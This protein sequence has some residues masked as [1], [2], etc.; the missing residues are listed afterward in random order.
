MYVMSIIESAGAGASTAALQD[1]LQRS[2]LGGEAAQ[3][4]GQRDRR[5]AALPRSKKTLRVK[6]TTSMLSGGGGGSGGGSGGGGGG[7]GS[8][9]LGVREVKARL[10]ALGARN[11]IWL[12][13]VGTMCL[14]SLSWLAS[15]VGNMLTCVTSQFWCKAWT[16]VAVSRRRSC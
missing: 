4:A 8:E 2:E 16:T 11:L 12:A 15:P 5:G 6:S 1:L 3:T 7:G 13:R 14:A 10:E 9:V